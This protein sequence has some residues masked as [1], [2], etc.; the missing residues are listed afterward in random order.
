[1]GPLGGLPGALSRAAFRFPGLEVFPSLFD[2]VHRALQRLF[3]VSQNPLGVLLGLLFQL[4]GL[5]ASLLQNALGFF[6]RPLDDLALTPEFR[7]IG[8]ASCR[9]RVE[10]SGGVGGVSDE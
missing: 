8:R 3:E 9:E 2:D 6:P 10:A 1:A 7:E 5:L 4:A